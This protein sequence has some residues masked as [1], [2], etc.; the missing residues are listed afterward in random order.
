MYFVADLEYLC[1]LWQILRS[2]CT[3]TDFEVLGHVSCLN[4]LRGVCMVT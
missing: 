1:V 3:R 4:Q 2:L